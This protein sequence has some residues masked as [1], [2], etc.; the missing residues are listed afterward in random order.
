MDSENS[1]E[2]ELALIALISDSN[3]CSRS[4]R[5]NFAQHA[6]APVWKSKF[7]FEK[8]DIVAL[9]VDSAFLIHIQE[10]SA[11]EFRLSRLYA[12]WMTYP[13]CLDDLKDLFGREYEAI[14][15]ISNAVQDHLYQAFSHRLMFD[16]QR[17][18]ES[19]IRAYARAIFAKGAPLRT[20]V[21]FIDCTVR[22]MC[23]PLQ[24]QKY[25]YNGHKRKHALKS[26]SVIAPD[27][28]VIHLSGPYAGP[29]HGAFIL[30]QSGLLEAACEHLMF[31]EKHY[32]FYGDPAYGQQDHII[33]PFKDDEQECNKRMSEV[34]VSVEW[35]FGKIVRYWALIDFAKNQKLR[36]QRLVKMY[37]MAAF[38][39]NVHTCVREPN[40]KVFSCDTSK[41]R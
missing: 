2:E 19:T 27:G 10:S 37:A 25:V 30:Q 20:C 11:T 7:R 41:S 23:R 28:I 24:H 5:F 32:V 14:S 16:T 9:I 8:D 31:D 18:T 22:G 1:E 17:L 39:S 40:V 34:R 36:L 13:A 35:G 15:S 26:Q 6:T 4:N 12:F 29:R 21:G 38:L 33:A 3:S